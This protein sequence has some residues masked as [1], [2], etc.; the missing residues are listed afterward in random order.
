MSGE[1][2]IF[3]L[4]CLHICKVSHLKVLQKDLILVVVFGSGSGSGNGS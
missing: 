1:V 4:E 3:G 2:F